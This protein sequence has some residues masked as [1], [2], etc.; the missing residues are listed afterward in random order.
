MRNGLIKSAEPGVV[1][2]RN[3]SRLNEEIYFPEV[4]GHGHT[5]RLAL[6]KMTRPEFRPTNNFSAHIALHIRM[7][8]FEKPAS[9]DELR[10]G[11]KNSSTPVDWFVGILMGLRERL[12]DVR[13]IVYSDGN[14]LSLA[15]LLGLPNVTRAPQQPSV[16]DM[17]CI[18]R[19]TILISSG[20]GFSMWG[21]FLGDVP[22]ICFPGQRFVRVLGEPLDVDYEP[23][24]ESINELSI[25]FTDSMLKHFYSR[26]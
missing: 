7:G 5:L 1:V 3:Q 4:V 19:A 26:I 14:D 16:T 17:L 23:E 25:D 20:S 18:S 21:S 10:A 22:R 11:R 2:F 13:A 9:I 12:G 24:V 15:K 6:E 8:D